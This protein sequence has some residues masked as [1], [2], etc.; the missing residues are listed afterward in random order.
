MIWTETA[1]SE[2][3][4]SDLET[5]LWSAANQL[6]A[7]AA[8]KPSEFSPIVLGLIF[9]QFSGFPDAKFPPTL[10]YSRQS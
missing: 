10:Q 2:D 1:S 3:N 4:H 7:N 6:W 9:P 8:L 5:R